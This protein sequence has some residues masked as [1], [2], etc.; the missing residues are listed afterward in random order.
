MYEASSL[1]Q[2]KHVYSQLLAPEG[3]F[4]DIITSISDLIVGGQLT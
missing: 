3:N 2:C 4:Y 1:A